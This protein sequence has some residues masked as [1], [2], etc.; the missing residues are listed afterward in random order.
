MLQL[1][2]ETVLITEEG[3]IAM[4][5][6]RSQAEGESKR[7]KQLQEAKIPESQSVTQDENI[8]KSS[9]NKALDGSWR[10]TRDRLAMS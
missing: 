10:Q 1:K 6:G 7:K 9:S 2:R 5:L 4:T 3:M 8:K